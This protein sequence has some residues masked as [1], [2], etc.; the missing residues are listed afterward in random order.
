MTQPRVSVIVVSRNRPK[1][2]KLCLLGL[3]QLYYTNFEIIVVANADS[4][5]GL[6]SLD[7]HN[8]IKVVAFED[9]NISAARNIGVSN[10]GGDLIAF[11]DD[12]AVPEPTWLDHLIA[13]FED[14]KVAAAGG[15]V[16]GRNGISFQ[17]KGRMA[18]ADGQSVDLPLEGDAPRVFAGEPGRAIRTEG[19]NMAIRRDVLQ[20]LG[21]FD[22][23]FHFYM[24]ETDL[25]M[26]LADE[27]KST[28]IVP[29]AQ[30]HHGYRESER[31]SSRRVPLSLEDIGRSTAVFCRKHGADLSTIE[32]TN[33]REQRARLVDLMT[34][35]EIMP[36]E[37]G[38]LLTT[39]KKGWA[40]GLEA[41]FGARAALEPKSTFQR[42][43]T[44][45][46]EPEMSFVTGRFWQAR[47]KK[48]VSIERLQSKG[49]VT[50]LLFS[51]STLYHHVRFVEPGIWLQTGGQFG[52]SER[53]QSLVQ[54]LSHSTRMRHETDRTAKTRGK[55]PK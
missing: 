16:I 24:D 20:A 51:L 2:L 22:D 9:A 28:A 13:P 54:L 52:R 21:G 18:F 1:S 32:I 15:Y 19:T 45:I 26:R 12:D 33:E 8:K 29:L 50:L 48:R 31:R 40:D 41:D 23:A 30:V 5:V 39:L 25:N 17:W 3:S 46:A 42:F 35:G 27:G 55:P 34:R 14:A 6:D 4:R 7:F 37:V 43:E 53:N 36:G 10:A 11:I 44:D 47:Q 38:K 49:R